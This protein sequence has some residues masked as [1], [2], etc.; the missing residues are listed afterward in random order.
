[1]LVSF[2]SS[3]MGTVKPWGPDEKRVNKL[4]FIGRNL[5]RDQLKKDFEACIV[6]TSLGHT[7]PACA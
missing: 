1:M 3:A 4:I 7:A 6:A 5:D 2:G